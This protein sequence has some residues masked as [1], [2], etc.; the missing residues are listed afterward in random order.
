[1][2]LL[3]TRPHNL[4]TPYKTSRASQSET[5]EINSY[6]STVT[7][8]SRLP[9]QTKHKPLRPQITDVNEPQEVA[10]MRDEMTTVLATHGVHYH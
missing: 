2:P 3:K 5:R 9:V 8:S 1:M 10:V 4:S 6:K 7:T